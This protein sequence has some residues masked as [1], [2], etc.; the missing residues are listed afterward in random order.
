MARTYELNYGNKATVNLGDYE[1]ESP[2][3]NQKLIITIDDGIEINIAEEFEEMRQVVDEQLRLNVAKIRQRKLSTDLKDLRF[4][5]YEGK[6]YPSVTSI[7]SLGEK[8]DIPNLELYGRR[9]E[10]LHRIFARTITDGKYV[11]DVTKEEEQALALIGGIS[12][13]DFGFKELLTNDRFDFRLSEVEVYN[14]E[15][16]YAGRFDAEGFDGQL[17]VIFDLKSGSM[18]KEAMTRAFMQLAA[19]AHCRE[20]IQALI[21]LPVSPKT[22]KEPIIATNSEMERYWQMFLAKR[23]EFKEKFGL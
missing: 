8:L 3:Y 17:K 16:L 6:R 23:R 15:H 21:I 20:G 7:I 4:Y 1:N 11:W 22:K 5:E 12:E 9:G 13:K 14:V 19:Y 10:I 2:M 18:N